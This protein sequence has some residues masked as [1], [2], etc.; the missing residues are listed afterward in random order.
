MLKGFLHTPR[1]SYYDS[2]VMMFSAIAYTDKAYALWIGIIVVW[3]VSML[4]IERHY[5]KKG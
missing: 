1:Y 2:I 4:F 5:K 3:F